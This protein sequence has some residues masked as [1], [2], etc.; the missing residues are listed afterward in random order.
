MTLQLLLVV[1]V[2]LF[3]VVGMLVLRTRDDLFAVFFAL[4]FVYT[5]FTQVGYLL[6]PEVA[7]RLGAYYGQAR[8][9]DYWLFVN[10]SLLAVV[11]GYLLLNLTSPSERPV[12]AL[13]LFPAVEGTA[14]RLGVL[15]VGYIGLLGGL[16]VA[17]YEGVGYASIDNPV[18][19]L[20]VFCQPLV[21]IVLY[22]TARRY[23]PTAATRRTALALGLLGLVLF[24][25]IS[26]RAGQRM[27][28]IALFVGVAAFELH[29][30]TEAVRRRPLRLIGLGLAGVLVLG[31]AG[32]IV[33]VRGAFEDIPITALFDVAGTAAASGDSS[34][35]EGLV[36]QDYFA[37]SLQL[38]ASLEYQVVIPDEVLRS[39]I[40]NA[41]P[42]FGYP[43]LSETVGRLIDPRV[44]RNEGLAYYVLTEG[45]NA[46]GWFGI[47]YNAIVINF[48]L[49]LWRLF[50]RTSD[51]RINH[52][53]L[54]V[55]IGM[56][57]TV[58][59]GPSY[60]FVRLAYLQ[61]LPALFLAAVAVGL[62]P[63]VPRLR[64]GRPEAT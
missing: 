55:T 7:A 10:G 16:F 3:L 61:L 34:I 28:L 5:I 57:V 35:L 21:L 40:F 54:A 27:N 41:L 46:A 12:R 32:R 50:S 49:A 4:L 45:F 19:A 6:A 38:F 36:L 47:L 11:S 31:L 9:I 24:L 48:G 42:G 23:G 53:M 29:P 8:F 22:G 56:L 2:A 33:A 20:L 59:R 60:L 1:S 51:A 62:M 58:V 43:T 17:N 25:A 64:A 13:I 44:S 26:V 15:G 52:L 18:L 37:P 39:T 14:L 63:V 30:L